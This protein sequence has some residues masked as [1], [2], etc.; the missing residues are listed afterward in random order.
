MQLAD[1]EGEPLILPRRS[2]PAG[3]FR[4]TVEHLRADVGFKPRVAYDLD[5]LPQRRPSRRR[6]IAVVVM[7]G[8]TLG[9]V[10]PGAVAVPLANRPAGSRTIEALAPEAGRS[11]PGADDLARRTP[12]EPA[13]ARSRRRG[14]QPASA[15]GDDAGAGVAMNTARDT[16]LEHA[17]RSGRPRAPM[18]CR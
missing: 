14:C 15:D 4:T 8:L 9:T 11:R 16:F 3:R 7:H 18:I 12:P 13:R 17:R 1:L 5:D 10:P 2:T 6:A